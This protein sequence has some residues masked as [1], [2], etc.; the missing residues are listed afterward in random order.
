[1]RLSN[2]VDAL[3]L[4]LYP[5]QTRST[6]VSFTF[7][8]IIIHLDQSTMLAIRLR[9]TGKRSH[10]T[11]RLIVSEKTRSPQSRAVEFLGSYDPHTHPPT[12]NLKRERVEHWLKVG[13]KPSETVHNI[14]VDA[15]LMPGPKLKVGRP[16]P[17]VEPAEATVKVQPPAVTAPETPAT[18]LQPEKTP[19]ATK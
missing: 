7:G 9:R 14:L 13:A 15:G 6:D 17:K 3:P 12:V 2:G 5:M 18:D 10:A 19:A 8:F 11:F 1:M 4:F 16:K